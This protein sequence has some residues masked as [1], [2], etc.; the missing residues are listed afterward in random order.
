MKESVGWGGKGLMVMC[1]ICM[2]W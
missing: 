2:Q 1:C